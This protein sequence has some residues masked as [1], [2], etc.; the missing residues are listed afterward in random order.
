MD[1]PI[2]LYDLF[3][4]LEDRWPYELIPALEQG[5]DPAKLWLSDIN[6]AVSIFD[7]QTNS[8]S[9]RVGFS[10][11]YEINPLSDTGLEFRIKPVSQFLFRILKLDATK[12]GYLFVEIG[13][14]GPDIIIEGLPVEILLP[15]ELIFG[16]PNP[17][18]PDN[19]DENPDPFIGLNTQ[20]IAEAKEGFKI[21]PHSQ[22]VILRNDYSDEGGFTSVFT[23][24]R[25]H[26]T[27]D[28]DIELTTA[29]PINFGRCGFMNL[30]V[31]AIHDFQIFPSPR[32][33][34]DEKRKLL[35][36]ANWIRHDIYSPDGSGAFGIRS[37]E[38]NL[39]TGYLKKAIPEGQERDVKAEWVFEDLIFN[40][41]LGAIGLP[42]PVHLTVGFRRNV[43]NFDDTTDIFSFENT[44]ASF[45]FKLITIR[46][47]TLYLQTIQGGLNHDV[48]LGIT[49]G[50]K[51][52]EDEKNATKEITVEWTNDNTIRVGFTWLPGDD[53]PSWLKWRFSDELIVN[54]INIT[55]GASINKIRDDAS[56]KNYFEITGSFWIHD[57]K[58]KWDPGASP[59]TDLPAPVSKAPVVVDSPPDKPLSLI[60]TNIGWRQGKP[61]FDMFSLPEGYSPRL[62]PL[63]ID[64]FEM[65]L[66]TENDATYFSVSGGI[67][68]GGMSSV[69][70]GGI[71]FKRMRF[72]IGGNESADRFK[73]DGIMGML[74]IGDYFKLEIG[75]YY[76]DETNIPENYHKEEFGYTGKLELKLATVWTFATDLI[77]GK[78]TTLDTQESFH[79][80]MLQ[81]FIGYLP[82]AAYEL[83]NIRG[84]LAINMKPDLSPEDEAQDQLK[85]Y[86]WQKSIDPLS[87][88][89]SR[90]LEGWKVRKDAISA[91]GGLGISFNGFGDICKLVAFFVYV[92]SPQDEE[93]GF[94]FS[95]EFYFGKPSSN[96]D[97]QQTPVAW[98]VFEY[99]VNN[100]N[101]AAQLGFELTLKKFVDNAPAVLADVLKIKGTLFIGNN[102][103]TVA[104]GRIDDQNSWAMVE[105]DWD[106]F[107]VIR[108]YAR[109]ALCF[110][111]V[112]GSVKGVGF[113]IRVEGGLD[114]GFFGIYF[115]AGVTFT[116]RNFTTGSSDWVGLLSADIGGYVK[117]FWVIRFGL[118]VHGEIRVINFNPTTY[119]ALIRIHISTSW[120]L[121]DIS[122]S[123]ETQSGE[124][125]PE[126]RTM[127][128]SP[129]ASASSFHA[130]TGKNTTVH[131]Q[132]IA[133]G[134]ISLVDIP[135][136]AI[137][138][139]TRL[140]R[141]VEAIADTQHPLEAVATDS[142]IIVK[143]SS[144][145]DQA[146]GIGNVNG[147][148]G[149]Q[150]TG[151]DENHMKIKY[152]LT[153]IT[154][155]RRPRY[156]I[157]RNWSSLEDHQEMVVISPQ[158]GE[159]VQGT[160]TFEQT[161]LSYLWDPDKQENGRNIPMNL[162]INSDTPFT[163]ATENMAGDENLLTE[164]PEWPCCRKDPAHP[165][166]YNYRLETIGELNRSLRR[167]FHLVNGFEIITTEGFIVPKAITASD[168][169]VNVAAFAIDDTVQVMHMIFDEEAIAASVYVNADFKKV[170]SITLFAENA[171]GETVLTKTHEFDARNKGW[172]LVLISG[173]S[174]R[175]VRVVANVTKRQ[176][177]TLFV[178]M[179]TWLSADEY[180][181]LVVNSK[182]C[183][184]SNPNRS[185]DFSGNGG[186]FFLPNHEYEIALT[187]E[188][189]VKHN[190]TEWEA[191]SCTEFV[192]FMTKGLPG[193]NYTE[194]PGAEIRPYVQSAYPAIRPFIYAE[195]P[196]TLVLNEKFK[197][198]LPVAARRP[199]GSG[200]HVQMMDLRLSVRKDLDDKIISPAE[201][202]PVDWITA[203]AEARAIVARGDFGRK[204]APSRTKDARVKRLAAIR[205]ASIGGDCSAT[206]ITLVNNTILV[207]YPTDR[208]IADKKY[209]NRNIDC[210]AVLKLENPVYINHSSF[211]I[212]DLPAFG[213]GGWAIRDG[214]L[215]LEGAA[216]LQAASFGDESWNYFLLRTE[217]NIQE[218]KAGVRIGKNPVDG[219]GM[220]ILAEKT[221]DGYELTVYSAYPTGVLAQAMISS[222][223]KIQMSVAAYDD[224]LAIS[225]NNEALIVTR[226]ETR[227]GACAFVVMGT[228]SYSNLFVEP[229]PMYSF[230]FRVSRF[231]SFRDHI[232][233]FE[234][235]LHTLSLLSDTDFQAAIVNA[236]P[237]ISEV[238]QAGKED[239]DRE[240]LF[241][242]LAA[243]G[244]IFVDQEIQ[245]SRITAVLTSGGNC[246]GLLLESAESLDV[247]TAELE[248]TLARKVISDQQ[249]P[250]GSIDGLSDLLTAAK[251]MTKHPSL[252]VDIL[253]T[254]TFASRLAEA[255]LH[256]LDLLTDFQETWTYHRLIRSIQV[257]RGT[258][259][260]KRVIR[261]QYQSPLL[262]LAGKG[263]LYL[264]YQHEEKQMTVY[265]GSVTN[266]RKI[267]VTL[268]GTVS[269][270]L[271]RQV[272]FSGTKL[273]RMILVPAENMVCY[274][275]INRQVTEWREAELSLLQNHNATDLFVLP[276]GAGTFFE[277]GEWRLKFKLKRMRYETT[278]TTDE[279]ATYSG[280]EVIEF[281][282]T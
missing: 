169:P 19:Q 133:S 83:N 23:H 120:W 49:T 129:L 89:G 52:P 90:R 124:T 205:N 194:E 255:G 164:N 156:G 82:V 103:G 254:I 7:L 17:H 238:M 47:Y 210:T 139:N 43:D 20:Q 95:I 187:C 185:T 1:R 183:A 253:N 181:K 46:V 212:S 80:F 26:I 281:E 252:H 147:D 165:H 11:R 45:F 112:E 218:G 182:S 119:D 246:A 22:F 57:I 157:N 104:L 55:T 27:P 54:L 100:G 146:L 166:W 135:G 259:K 126:T 132:S 195:E 60:I 273:I 41:G 114:A 74:V 79:Y 208:S 63:T 150:L 223:D 227:E 136:L 266:A 86:H 217:I 138:E 6:S 15:P 250:L 196:V 191:S 39:E 188:I 73:M 72:R 127:I 274:C 106:L 105:W 9:D 275:D 224:Q 144:P 21:D 158:T 61:S 267:D 216:T 53:Y 241:T 262:T 163:Y 161:S 38:F 70:E 272:E 211:A 10:C 115:Y 270:S 221:T 71:W 173:K 282:I 200:E 179:A 29:A 256:H 258:T 142:T 16:D 213:L 260:N 96:N 245:Q 151:D 198:S 14:E 108:T 264:E 125:V 279:L 226:G 263:I 280:E 206:D 118:D 122:W 59:D 48:N 236:D 42:V 66:L 149:T 31:L 25:L 78:M 269:V 76:T 123:F 178:D 13:P 207:A 214:K 140:Q 99:D 268:K 51:A 186:L 58:A 117:L 33:L 32:I 88:P 232:N 184:G 230:N 116:Y 229:L 111:Y 62:G 193:L 239:A 233:D 145:V 94:A 159:P 231:D 278:D 35:D 130:P 277:P 109:V 110:E 261:P 153:S 121:P 97:Q 204:T 75:G 148:W 152:R 276:S 154:V 28:L 240:T 134:L 91:G 101:F 177:W 197:L 160:I 155:R 170:A 64:L 87:V 8:S 172:V 128:G 67:R 243:A 249:G 93:A 131:S 234:E 30:P 4:G 107:E 168:G 209:W 190:S 44:A 84:L 65:G 202:P 247:T 77:V 143:F 222:S 228:A 189:S 244:G 81:F 180:I 40:I 141:F 248:I 215:L 219:S 3:P 265:V 175:S 50:D 36:T 174:F 113:A 162:L 34:F 171:K 251:G 24:L 56:F 203:T 199:G 69:W 102:P 220:T 235:S 176:S 5:S 192:Y 2:R 237:S 201:Q 271:G 242:R 85:Y 18:T 225:I 137:P 12:K 257:S 92:Y 37:I 167:W 98:G 68:L